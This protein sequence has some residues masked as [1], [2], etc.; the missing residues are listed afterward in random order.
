MHL[1]KFSNLNEIWANW[2]NFI[3]IWAKLEMVATD[4]SLSVVSRETKP[5]F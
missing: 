5:E 2:D 4:F 3:Q 1:G